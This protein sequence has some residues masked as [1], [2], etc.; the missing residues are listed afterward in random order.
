MQGFKSPGLGYEIKILVVK[1]DVYITS[2]GI[3]R[4]LQNLSATTALGS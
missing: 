1:K 3:V 4:T 2:Q